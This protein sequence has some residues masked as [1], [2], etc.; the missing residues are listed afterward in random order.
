MCI[1][2]SRRLGRGIY[3]A[4]GRFPSAVCTAL[5]AVCSCHFRDSSGDGQLQMDG[6]MRGLAAVRGVV[7]FRALLPDWYAS[8]K[9]IFIINK[10]ASWKTSVKLLF[11][12]Y[13]RM[14]K[15]FPL[16]RIC[17]RARHKRAIG[18]PKGE[19]RLHKSICYC[20]VPRT[21]SYTHLDVYKRQLQRAVELAQ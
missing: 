14:H 18:A 10:A 11:N 7:C 21:V 2:D 5:Y 15:R 1:R 12:R 20:I 6:C 16:G 19:A 17:A 8:P 13:F 3:P 9:T 4:F